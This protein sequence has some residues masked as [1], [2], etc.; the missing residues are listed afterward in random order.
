MLRSVLLLVSGNAFTGVLTL[1][2]NLL[3]ARLIGVEDYGIAATFT[4]AMSAVEM[5][6]AFGLQQQIVQAK[7]GDDPRLQAGLQCF[8]AMRGLFSAS[9]MFLSAHLIARFLGIEPVGWAFQVLALVPLL[10]GFIHFDVYRLNRNFRYLPGIL[11]TTVPAALSTLLIW[12]L[13]LAM[14]DYRVMLYA[15]LIQVVCTIITSHLVA[16]RKYKLLFDTAILRQGMRFG[17]PILLDSLLL[18]AVFHGEKLIVG[19]E[20]G[21]SALAIFAMGVTLTLTPTVVMDKSVQSFFLPQLSATQDDPARF[22][23]LAMSAFQVYL[24][25]GTFLVVAVLFVGAPFISLVLGA[26]YAPLNTIL[27]WLA[28]LQA[29]RIFKGG[30]A[31]VALSR[32]QTEN[33]MIANIVRV[34]ALPLAWWVAHQTGD[35][36]LVIF[37]GLGGEMVGI[38]VAFFLARLRLRL[39][40]R[41]ML[42]PLLLSFLVLLVAGLHAWGQ[43]HPDHRA[44]PPAG[45]ISLAVGFFGL[46]ILTMRELRHYI[47][48]RT[49]VRHSE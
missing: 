15:V 10:N 28:I 8:Q 27:I 48:A 32:R 16:E 40:L 26:K 12:P 39:P 23:P 36:M 45:T 2:R 44:I 34:A 20:L 21:M 25:V 7:D 19:R 4:I 33:A 31:T 9:V 6:S 41:P 29:L 37:I 17:W 18:L 35:M 22:A 38:A 43:N 13:W 42:W 46:S 1:V 30:P 14:P 5:L 24:G 11:T 47:A 49:M 3:V